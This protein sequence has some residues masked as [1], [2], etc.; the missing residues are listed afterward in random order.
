MSKI[1][2]HDSA[3]GL[4]LLHS[5]FIGCV[6]SLTVCLMGAPTWAYLGFGYQTFVLLYL[7]TYPWHQQIDCWKV[8][9]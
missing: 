8:E 2:M 6:I 4:Q 5:L 1:Q 3:F 9:R 7:I